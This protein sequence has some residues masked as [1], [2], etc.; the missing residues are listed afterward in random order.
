MAESK[1]TPGCLFYENIVTPEDKEFIRSHCEVYSDKEGYF[2]TVETDNYEGCAM[3]TLPC[4][5]KVHR[6]LGK[7]IRAARTARKESRH[8]K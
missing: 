2:I 7:A 8:A 4:A 3:M 5:V 1:S 6:A